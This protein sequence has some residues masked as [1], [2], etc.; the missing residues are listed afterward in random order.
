[1]ARSWVGCLFGVLIPSA[2]FYLYLLL[3]GNT[4]V[5]IIL[6]LDI[7]MPYIIIVPSAEISSF[8]IN[9]KLDSSVHIEKAS[10]HIATFEKLRLENN[11]NE[12]KIYN[13]FL[14]N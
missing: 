7:D 4:H 3:N 2:V 9:G 1:M 6:I 13:R 8:K 11:H 5:F 12:V 14:E 10:P